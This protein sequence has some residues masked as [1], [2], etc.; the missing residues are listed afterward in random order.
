MEQTHPR[1]GPGNIGRSLTAR[2]LR[3]DLGAGHLEQDP[4]RGHPC[5]GVQHRVQSAHQAA[6]EDRKAPSE[7]DQPAA[8]SAFR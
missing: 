7:R 6:C 8:G 3:A 4:E 2:D 5:A 1:P